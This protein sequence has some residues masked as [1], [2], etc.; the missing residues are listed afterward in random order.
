MKYRIYFRF[1]QYEKKKVDSIIGRFS[2]IYI[3]MINYYRICFQS[4]FHFLLL[5]SFYR[6]WMY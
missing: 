6:R 2:M 3:D 4:S 1:H 5:L